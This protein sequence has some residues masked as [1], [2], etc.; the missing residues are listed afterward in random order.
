MY[1][2]SFTDENRSEENSFDYLLKNTLCSFVR[3][4]VLCIAIRLDLFTKIEQSSHQSFTVEDF[5]QWNISFSMIKYLLYLRLIERCPNS[6]NYQ[7]T[8]VTR[9]YLISTSNNYV[10]LGIGVWDYR[11]QYKFFLRFDQTLINGQRISEDNDEDSSLWKIFEQHQDPMIYFAQIMS[12]FTRCTINE[13]CDQLDLSSYSTLLDIGGSLGELSRIILQ[14]NPH[15][16]AFSF[17]LPALTRYARSINSDQSNI[18]Y[19]AG[20]F[21]D[22]QWPDEL[23][24]HSK[25]IDLITLKYILHDWN[26][27]QRECLLKKIFQLLNDKVHR[28]GGQGTLIVMEKML[29]SNRENI[30]SLSTS[31]SMAIECGDG[32][33]YDGT[34][35]EYQKLLTQ[36]GF[37]RIQVNKL[38]GPMVALLAH[39]V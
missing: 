14:R 3:S 4:Q 18:E 8:P 26:Y 33:G 27:S 7:C 16:N 34:Q 1:I 30:T 37:Q 21:F 36:T 10:G 20:D 11:R 15:L 39:I 13:L 19:I 17:D 29:D 12:S 38:T 2:S 28:Y 35:E 32:I 25:S 22:E 9:R 5:T 6:S 24:Q 31:I 23:L